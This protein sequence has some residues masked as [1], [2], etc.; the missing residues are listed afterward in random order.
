MVG[1]LLSFQGWKWNVKVEAQ[2]R[3]VGSTPSPGLR[4]GERERSQ[5]PPGSPG[6]GC[7]RSQVLGQEVPGSRRDLSWGPG[8]PL[9][10]P[11]CDGPAEPRAPGPASLGSAAQLGLLPPC[12]SKIILHLALR[13]QESEGKGWGRACRGPP[14]PVLPSRSPRDSQATRPVTVPAS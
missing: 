4:S 9:E 5:H 1:K 10:G 7:R 6:R 14:A 2:L 3:V 13:E 8:S 12:L 11:A